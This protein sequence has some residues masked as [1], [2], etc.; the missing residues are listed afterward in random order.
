MLMQRERHT[1]P[2][3][4]FRRAALAVPVG[5]FTLALIT[6]C[7]WLAL[8]GFILSIILFAATLYR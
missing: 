6:G 5:V 7:P 3:P 8:L 2:H 4:V 1:L